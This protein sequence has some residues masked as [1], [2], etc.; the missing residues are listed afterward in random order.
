MSES[1]IETDPKLEEEPEPVLVDTPDATEAQLT[2]A[3]TIQ[4]L[5]AKVE[6]LEDMLENFKNTEKVYTPFDTAW[7]TQSREFRDHLNAIRLAVPEFDGNSASPNNFIEFCRKTEEYVNLANL[8]SKLVLQFVSTRLKG[9]A[10]HWL[11]LYSNEHPEV[12]SSWESLK[13][14]LFDRFYPQEAQQQQLNHLMNLRQNGKP[15][16]VFV[17]EFS[18]EAVIVEGLNDMLKVSLFL[19]AVD[20]NVRQQ[21]EISAA[22]LKSFSAAT[23][24]AI[25]LGKNGNELRTNEVALVTKMARKRFARHPYRALNNCWY[26]QRK[27]HTARNCN[28]RI[29]DQQTPQRNRDFGEIKNEEQANVAEEEIKVTHP[30]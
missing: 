1:R 27:G 20:Q 14:A 12:K 3:E 30:R 6:E 10:S 19:A 26:C 23:M 22:N 7:Q 28:A 18:Q 2:H 5:G 13:K 24:A 9:L 25:R 17:E 4:M 21:I 8:P 29:R 11:F 15:I 16:Q